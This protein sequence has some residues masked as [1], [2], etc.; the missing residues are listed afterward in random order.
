MRKALAVAIGFFTLGVFFRSFV[1]LGLSFIF[2]LSLGAALFFIWWSISRHRVIVL[3]SV[4]LFSAALGIFRYDIADNFGQPPHLQEGHVSAYA[5]VVDES[6][7]RETHANLTVR[8]FE[9]GIDSP[10][11]SERVLVVASL[12]PEFAYGDVISL[13]GDLVLPKNF[14]SETGGAEFDYVSYLAKDNIYYEMFYPCVSLVEHNRGNVIKEMLFSFKQHVMANISAVVPEP[15]ASLLGGL[16]FG[17]K[18]SLGDK[19]LAD[20]RTAGVIHIVVLSGYNVTIVAEAIMRTLS[21]LPRAIG[22]SMGGIGIIFFAIMTGGNATIVRAS[23]MALLVVLARA[24]GRVY[25]ITAGLIAAGFLMILA[26]PKILA[27]DASFQLSFLATLGLVYLAPVIERYFHFMPTRFQL[28][29]FALS[30]VATQIFVLPLLLYKVG[31]FSTVA[32]FANI[33]ILAFVPLTML[34]GFLTGMAGFIAPIVSLPLAFVSYAL[35]AYELFVVEMLASLPYASIAVPAIP[36][37]AVVF[38]YAIYGFVIWRFHHP[39]EA[40]S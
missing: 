38:V 40:S 25:E 22:M 33:L 35:L 18:R 34:F 21:F 20:F 30:T 7:L 16:V 3:F 6:D 15:H 11:S 32:L 28:R 10:L 36:F 37:A 23:I 1:D 27:F 19:L 24:T 5:L 2:F 29:E 4:A 31:Q 12:H 17:A 9:D 39:A 26:N 14:T 13:D 8:L